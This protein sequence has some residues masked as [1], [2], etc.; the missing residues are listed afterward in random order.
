MMDSAGLCV[1]AA[2]S[3]GG[4]C[5]CAASGTGAFVGAKRGAAGHA[6]RLLWEL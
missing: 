5:R 4:Q 3:G 6:G 2:C 1:A